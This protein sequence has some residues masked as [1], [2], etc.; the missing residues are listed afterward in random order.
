VCACLGPRWATRRAF[1]PPPPVWRTGEGGRGI[2]GLGLVATRVATI[3]SKASLGNPQ[4][5][6]HCGGGS[7]G[8][9]PPGASMRSVWSPSEVQPNPS[10]HT[11]RAG[12]WA[13]RVRIRWGTFRGNERHDN[14][15]YGL[16][17]RA[18]VVA[19]TSNK[20]RPRQ[21]GTERGQGRGTNWVQSQSTNLSVPWQRR[22]PG[23]ARD[24]EPGA[25]KCTSRGIGSH[26]G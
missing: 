15:S 16:I 1:Y 25:S 17:W 10:A 13:P 8:E 12:Y 26:A 4:K 18:Q 11:H 3:C 21:F 23:L 14:S 9:A 7:E 6:A 20:R 19:D 24:Q 5:P 22:S 2:K